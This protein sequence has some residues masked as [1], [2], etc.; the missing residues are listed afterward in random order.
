MADFLD[1]H[2]NNPLAAP[3]PPYLSGQHIGCLAFRRPAP[4]ARLKGP[5]INRPLSED[6]SRWQGSCPGARSGAT[7]GARAMKDRT[8][9]KVHLRKGGYT[10]T[11]CGLNCE[12]GTHRKIADHPEEVTCQRCRKAWESPN[13]IKA[14]VFRAIPVRIVCP[15]C[16]EII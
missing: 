16:G 6:P 10:L 9:E 11:F 7:L 15:K 5:G 1:Y 4:D 14:A 8:N 13:R 3:P 2:E 12:W